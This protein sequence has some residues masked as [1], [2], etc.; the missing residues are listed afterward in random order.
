M[1]IW[2]KLLNGQL[3]K[4]TWGAVRVAVSDDEDNIIAAAQVLTRK[5]LGTCTWSNLRLQQ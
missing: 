1:G 3:L 5:G 4:N 2:C